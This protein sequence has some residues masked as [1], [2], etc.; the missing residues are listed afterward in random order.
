M[1]TQCL[2][3]TL[4]ILIL[5]SSLLY[6]QE[7]KIS[8]NSSTSKFKFAAKAGVNFSNTFGDVGDNSSFLTDINIGA[9]VKIPT[10]L[11]FGIQAEPQISRIGNRINGETATRFT[12]LDIPVLAQVYSINDWS[13]EAG[14]KV[15]VTLDQKQR[16][17]ENLES[18]DRLKTITLGITAGAT[19][20]FDSNW[21]GQFRINHWFSDIIRADA[22]DTEG[23]SILL[24]QFSVGYW[25]D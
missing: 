17:D 22:G 9:V 20:N 13:F 23:T 7:D 14:P 21:F 6:A 10:N 3:I 4:L 25:F 1:K 11:N 15:A 24:I 2:K 16:R 12:F 18:I 5:S 8:S 19:Y